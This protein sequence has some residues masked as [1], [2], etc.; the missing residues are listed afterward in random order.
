MNRI[1][2]SFGAA[3]LRDGD[4]LLQTAE[5]LY[6][7]QQS[8]QRITAVVS[9]LEGV[10]DMLAESVQLG[11]YARVYNKLLSIHQSHARKLIRNERDRALLIQDVG[12]ILGAYN[13][14]G[15]SMVNRGPTPAEAAAILATGERLAARLLT[16]HLQHRGV[17][18]TVLNASEIIITDDNH[19]LA[20][21][22]AEASR[23]HI[24]ERLL[25]RLEEGYIVL[26]NGSTGGTTD[27]RPTRLADGAHQSAALLAA[28]APAEALWL[29]S[30]RDGIMTADPALVTDARTLPALSA[31]D[32][33]ELARYGMNVPSAA[34][35]APVLAA[36][37]PVFIRSIY[38]PA[39][40]GTYIQPDRRANDVRALVVKDRLRLII[41][42][43][44]GLNAARGVSAL[45]RQNTQAITASE[46][47]DTLLY[48][49][50]AAEVNSARLTLEDTFRANQATCSVAESQVGL[51]T[52]IGGAQDSLTT[53][54]QQI[55]AALR[56]HDIPL[57]RTVQTLTASA[58]H[59]GISAVVPTDTVREAA[60]VIHQAVLT[61]PL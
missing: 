18:A 22:D 15:R 12:D 56:A 4:S 14:L 24:H 45:A 54:H 59:A 44:Y 17:R 28:A 43:G 48:F 61:Q 10:T 38:H 16:G 47:P 13:W 41:V 60:S 26:V 34:T 1:V 11:N 19:T 51:V 8:G 37:I 31:A 2:M 29:W 53:V 21:P 27:G 7:Y 55:E 42:S 33:D 50:G 36:E 5:V 30:D 57:L 23:A 20:V 49:V 46:A 35:L 3:A 52:L 32:L 39:Q 58:E 9:A 6:Q 25:P 40:T